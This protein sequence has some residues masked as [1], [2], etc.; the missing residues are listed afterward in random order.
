MGVSYVTHHPFLQRLAILTPYGKDDF[1]LLQLI[2]RFLKKFPYVQMKMQLPS[3]PEGELKGVE[4]LDNFILTLG[5]EL[6]LQKN[7]RRSLQRATKAGIRWRVEQETGAF[8]EHLVAWNLK[9]NTPDLIPVATQLIKWA[10]ERKVFRMLTAHVEDLPY[11]AGM[12]LIEWKGRLINLF[13][14]TH[15]EGRKQG[16][17]HYLI[18]RLLVE[19]PFQAQLLDFEG[20]EIPGVRRFYKGFGARTEHYYQLQKTVF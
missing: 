8:L 3:F 17:M 13:P 16:A 11:A 9:L 10:V 7:H 15:P 5:Q 12:G 20:S 6:V 2:E 1:G 14:F 18:E 19:N 4:R